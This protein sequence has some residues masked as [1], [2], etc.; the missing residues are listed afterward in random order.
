[1]ITK[2]QGYLSGYESLKFE[3]QGFEEIKRDLSCSYNFHL[4]YHPFK[5]RNLIKE[6]NLGEQEIHK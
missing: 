6:F 2:K 3:S 4:T 1:M 5:I